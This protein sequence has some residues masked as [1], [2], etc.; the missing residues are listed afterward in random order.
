VVIRT[1]SYVQIGLLS[2]QIKDVQINFVRITNYSE[3]V[4]LSVNIL[5]TRA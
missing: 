4:S 5:I 2:V 1:L 3:V